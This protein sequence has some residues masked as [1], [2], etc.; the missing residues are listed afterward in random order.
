MKK[1]LAYIVA[2][3]T[4]FPTLA[5]ADD[6]ASADRSSRFMLYMR[7][8][9]GTSDRTF[10]M[11]RFGLSFDRNIPFAS[12]TTPAGMRPHISLIDL[13][14]NAPRSQTLKLGGAAMLSGDGERSVWKSPWLW[15]G[16][17][18]AV[19]GISCATDNFPCDGDGSSGGSGSSG[20]GGY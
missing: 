15:V 6:F 7:A 4:V 12:H 17:G 8:S 20:G 5:T 19:I 14:F 3:S 11:P 18:A 10:T 2:A 1:I 16:V 9:L 13:Q